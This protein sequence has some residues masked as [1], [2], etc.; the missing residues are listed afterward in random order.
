MMVYSRAE[1]E[2]LGIEIDCNVRWENGTAHHP[3]SEELMRFLA[4]FDFDEVDDYFGWN[5]GGDGDN[6]ETMMYEMDVFLKYKMP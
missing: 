1:A 5:V 4:K 6:G 2:A 3:K